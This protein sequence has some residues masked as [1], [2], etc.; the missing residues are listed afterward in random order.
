MTKSYLRVLFIITS[1][2]LASVALL[3]F[4]V[5]PAGIY[6]TSRVNPDVYAD[7]L[8]K[9][10]FGVWT[11]DDL[12]NDR[13]IAKALTKHAQQVDCVVIGSSHVMQVSSERSHKSLRDECASILNL[14][15]SG[16]SIE[17]H[18]TLAYLSLKTGAPAKIVFG[19]D[20]WEFAYRKDIRWQ[21]YSDDYRQAKSNMI[22]PQ[23]RPSAANFDGSMLAN[24]INI[25]YTIRSAKTV[26]KRIINGIPT[27]KF[28]PKIDPAIGGS[29]PIRL[30]DGSHVYSAEYIANSKSTQIPL[31][32]STYKTDGI[33]NTRNA[34][35]DYRKLLLFLKQRGVEPI[36]MLTPYHENVWK[37]PT[38]PNV[39]AMTAT[40]SIVRELAREL[41]V[42]IIGSYDPHVIG[43]HK[44]EFYD[45]MHPKA[46]CLAKIRYK[47]NG[48]SSNI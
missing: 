41:G 20:P 43:C 22:S 1:I 25:D 7:L 4:I 47:T 17:D 40:D 37:A 12:F 34:I 44:D 6:H 13:L 9:S 19:I 24:L 3:N 30:K 35:A 36:L 32:G 42:K 39:R 15:V 8:R 10:K 31:G 18:I 28:S 26:A 48:F 2:L 33:L 27:I 29:A 45:F 38:S 46:E 16:A 5:D 23:E 21:A 11:P 14:G